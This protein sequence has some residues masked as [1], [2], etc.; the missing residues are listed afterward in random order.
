V[1]HGVIHTVI[2]QVTHHVLVALNHVRAQLL[3][4][5]HAQHLIVLPILKQVAQLKVRVNHVVFQKHGT[6]Q[7]ILVGTSPLVAM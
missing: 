6:A 1:V 5:A 7:Q 4:L 3:E 2:G